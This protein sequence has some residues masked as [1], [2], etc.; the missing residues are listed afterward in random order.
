[1]EWTEFGILRDWCRAPT[2][3][4]LSLI[5]KIQDQQLQCAIRSSDTLCVLL[6]NSLQF[7]MLMKVSAFIHLLWTVCWILQ[8]CYLEHFLKLY[9]SQL[10][11]LSIFVIYHLVYKLSKRERSKT[12]CWAQSVIF[13]FLLLSDSCKIQQYSVFIKRR[14]RLPE[15]IR[16]SETATSEFCLKM[17]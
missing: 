5:C 7:I 11:L 4:M 2:T 3:A 6:V 15:G 13:K 17:T 12:F 1:M 8:R 10:N 9:P 16:I 14:Q